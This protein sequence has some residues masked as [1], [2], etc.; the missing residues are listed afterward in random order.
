[1]VDAAVEAGVKL[2]I[3]SSLPEFAKFTHGN[4]KN[5]HHCKSS[6]GICASVSGSR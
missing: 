4:L 1:M 5:V 2:F 3:Y 6:F